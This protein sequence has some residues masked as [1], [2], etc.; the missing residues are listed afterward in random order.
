MRNE[1]RSLEIA[2]DTNWSHDPSRS[3]YSPVTEKHG[4][5]PA[6]LNLKL[7]D[8]LDLDVDEQTIRNMQEASQGSW[9]FAYP[10][11]LS[12]LR[13]HITMLEE[14]LERVETALGE[15]TQYKADFIRQLEEHFVSRVKDIPTVRCVA[16]EEGPDGYDVLIFLEGW[17]DEAEHAIYRAEYEAL[18]ILPDVPVDFVV[19]PDADEEAVMMQTSETTLLYSRG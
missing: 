19:I 11:E 12:D 15:L 8:P 3:W 7:L 18:E 16:L 2:E 6:S 4:D 10:F 9:V 1:G 17:E 14:R 5:L 13:H